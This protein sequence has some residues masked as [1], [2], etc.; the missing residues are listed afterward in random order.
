[1]MRAL[2]DIPGAHVMN[3]GCICVEKGAFVLSPLPLAWCPQANN[4]HCH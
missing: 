1:M 4:L 3:V 2:L